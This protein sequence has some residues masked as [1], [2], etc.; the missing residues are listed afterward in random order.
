[1]SEDGALVRREYL[2]GYF[3]L[4]EHWGAVFTTGPNISTVPRDP[5]TEKPIIPVYDITK[6]RQR[7]AFIFENLRVFSDGHVSEPEQQ[8]KRIVGYWL[9]ELKTAADRSGLGKEDLGKTERQ[10][11]AM[12]AVS[13]SARAMEKSAGVAAAYVR[14]I[15]VTTYGTPDLDKQDYWGD[16]LLHKDRNKLHEVI[17]HPLVKHYYDKLLEDAGLYGLKWREKEQKYMQWNEE[18]KKW[19]EGRWKVDLERAKKSE[20]LR[21]LA[22]ENPYDEKDEKEK[23][24]KWKEQFENKTR[25]G[26]NDYIAEVLLDFDIKDKSSEEYK[27]YYETCWPEG[28][29]DFQYSTETLWA[30]ARL[31]ADVFLVDNFT[32]WEYEVDKDYLKKGIDKFQLKPSTVWGGNPLRA[33]LE[34]SFLPKRIKKVYGETIEERQKGILERLDYAFRPIDLLLPENVGDK[35]IREQIEKALPKPTMTENLKTYARYSDALWT[36]I[37]RSRAPG[38]PQ[39]TRETMGRDLPE[40]IELLDQVFGLAEDPEGKDMRLNKQLMGAITTRIL[41]MKALAAAYESTK[42]GFQENMATIFGEEKDRPFL[43]VLQFIYG[44]RYDYKRGFID[45]LLGARTRFVFKDNIFGAEKDLQDTYEILYTNDQ[46]PKTR[47]RALTL[48]KLKFGMT[49][50]S[51][52]GG[53]GAKRR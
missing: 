31:A 26:F 25:D 4:A 42:P 10:L 18:K 21:Y 46:D 51:A 20:L 12:M 47:G 15:T 29:E 9:T 28:P 32:D 8:W 23:W 39:W 49:V 19:E 34:P 5:K 36:T 22:K 30:A 41:E 35:A 50:L 3:P 33:V 13:S 7:N 14:Y 17:A 6:P 43:E 2:P 24:E 37:G 16:F 52:L 40:V 38:I 1:M 48:E 44:P 45:S 53:I 27:F 11:K